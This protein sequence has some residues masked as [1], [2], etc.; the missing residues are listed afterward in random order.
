[1]VLQNGNRHKL[2]P[3]HALVLGQDHYLSPLMPVGARRK[4]KTE[5]GIALM[6]AP[7]FSSAK[8]NLAVDRRVQSR[9]LA[10]SLHDAYMP[11]MARGHR[12]G[13]YPKLGRF[14]GYTVRDGSLLS[15]AALAP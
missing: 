8:P 14:L 7:A 2:L 12:P 5:I 15:E 4:T 9:D 11:A 6:A 1:M 13:R 3:H 10:E